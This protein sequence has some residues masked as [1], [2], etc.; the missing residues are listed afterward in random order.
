MSASDRMTTGIADAAIVGGGIIGLTIAEE[1][2][3]R[4][5]RVVVLDRRGPGG[6][7]SWAAGG[8]LAADYE[9]EHA[10]PLAD[11]ALASRA[12]WPALLGRLP[13]PEGGGRG[14]GAAPGTLIPATTSAALASLE[15][16]FEWHRSAKRSVETLTATRATAIEPALPSGIAGAI[17][18]PDDTAVDNRAVL[19]GLIKSLRARG[20]A[21]RF[22]QA[23]AMLIIDDDDG[24]AAGVIA[25]GGEVIGTR[26]VVDAAGVWAGLLKNVG[27]SRR[28]LPSALPPISP[29]LGQMLQFTSPRADALRAIVR[30]ENG[31]AIPRGDGRIVVG[32]TVE[33]QPGFS[34]AVTRAGVE[35]LTAGFRAALPSLADVPCTHAW[36]GLRPATADELPVVGAHPIIPGLL[37][38]CGH[39]RNG[40]LLA[41]ATAVAIADL[42]EGKAPSIPIDAFSATRNSLSGGIT[43]NG[44]PRALPSPAT[45]G[46]LLDALSQRR[47]GVAVA[48]N[49]EV[50]R[51]GD[52]DTTAL[53]ASDRVEII[54]AVGG[55]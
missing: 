13:L 22:V 34:K 44:K 54:H 9:F 45:V 30:W 5:R 19:H 42:V 25:G 6:E 12:M 23:E 1:L 40:I 3:R 7:A 53:R 35:M 2:A 47:N 17:H 51:R 38:A 27:G 32:A 28:A 39:Y 15:R 31:Y 20:D 26:Y 36:A 10:S 43:V 52:W 21:V 18:L 49:E 29:V 11:L 48:L 50:V 16:R 41:P 33:P 8:M 14:E 46:A 37:L 55:G 4:G 24:R